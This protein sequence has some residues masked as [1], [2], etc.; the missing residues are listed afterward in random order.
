MVRALTD[1]QLGRP[2]AAIDILDSASSVGSLPLLAPQVAEARALALATLDRIHEA[3]Q[4]IESGLGTARA[5]G[6]RY[7]EGMLLRA[8]QAIRQR[9]G[10]RCDPAEVDQGFRILGGLGVKMMPSPQ[11]TH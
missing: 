10:R 5:H 2:T 8:R 4:Q 1:V 11:T 3:E 9:A 7:E 6:L